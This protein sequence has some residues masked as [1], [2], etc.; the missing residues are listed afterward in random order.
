MKIKNPNFYKKLGDPRGLEM[1]SSEREC[2][3]MGG[4]NFKSWKNS[5]WKPQ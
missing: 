1:V 5:I 3:K 2:K 4:G